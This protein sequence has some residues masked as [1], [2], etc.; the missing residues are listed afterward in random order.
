MGL[1]RLLRRGT[2]EKARVSDDAGAHD[3]DGP[4][5]IDQAMERKKNATGHME[6][7]PHTWR[8]A[9]VRLK[10]DIGQQQPA[11]SG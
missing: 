7:I 3:M 10:L 6:C 11:G 2:R 9:G 1:A 5:A 8:R 4:T